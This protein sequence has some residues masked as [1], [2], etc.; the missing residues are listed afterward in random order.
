[1]S[2]TGWVV[3]QEYAGKIDADLDQATLQEVG[4]PVMVKGAFIGAFG[5]GFAGATPFGIRLL[6]P[7][8]DLEHARDVLGIEDPESE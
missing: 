6:V 4:I 3:L 2:S 5:P 1:M 7:A 8:E